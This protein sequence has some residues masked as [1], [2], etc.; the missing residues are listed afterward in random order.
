MMVNDVYLGRSLMKIISS[1][2]NVYQRG[3][4]E[5]WAI[6]VFFQL[7]RLCIPIFTKELVNALARNIFTSFGHCVLLL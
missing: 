4:S 2:A 1:Y 6:R 5:I 3:F 7:G